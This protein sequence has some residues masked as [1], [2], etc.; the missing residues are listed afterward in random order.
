MRSTVVVLTGPRSKRLWELVNFLEAVP[1]APPC[2]AQPTPVRQFRFTRL[3]RQAVIA[4]YESGR[5][6]ASLA[7]EYGV[8]RESISKLLRRS[9]V[10][11]RERRQMNQEQIDESVRLYESGLSLEQIGARLGWDHNTIYRQLKKRGV[12]MRGPNDWQHKK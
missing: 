6:M 11:I 4:G 10:V 2:K 8:K 7:A 9:G 1:F 3:Q 5:S 12:H